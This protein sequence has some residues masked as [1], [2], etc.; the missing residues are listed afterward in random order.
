MATI[1][2]RFPG[3]VEKLLVNYVGA[4][5][6]KGDALAQIYSPQFI[7]AAEEY[8]LAIQSGTSTGS[9]RVQ[10]TRERLLLAGFTDEQVAELTRTRQVPTFITYHSP[11]AGT[12]LEKK[13]VEGDYLAEGAPL[14]SV[15]DLSRVWV[16]ARVLESDLASVK[17]GQAVEVTSVAYPGIVFIGNVSFIYPT[18]E[19]DSR[20]V[21]VRI[22][23]SNRDMLLRPGMYVTALL[24]SPVGG[25]EPLEPPDLSHL[26]SAMSTGTMEMSAEPPITSATL[27]A[28]RP[29]GITTA[30]GG[31]PQDVEWQEGYT[32]VMHPEVLQE[33]GGLCNLCDCGMQMTKW[34]R[35]KVLAVPENAVIDTGT[36][37][38]VYVEQAAGVFD[39]RQVVLGARSGLW[40][41]VLS[42]LKPGMEVATNGS[43]LIDAENRLNP[44]SEINKLPTETAAPPSEPTVVVKGGY[45]P[46]VLTIAAGNHAV[47]SS[48]AGKR[49]HAHRRWSSL[50]SESRR[51]CLRSRRRSS[52]CPPPPPA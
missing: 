34:R 15:A 37:K 50:R 38:F 45:E 33:R 26:A 7:A 40:Y 11:I 9:S 39:A 51:N 47:S 42:G 13:A 46:E 16:Q 2:N 20:S 27:Y 14:F 18:V 48:T 22:E 4:K 19:P 31:A 24:R 43:F 28:S 41:P 36:R 10:A 44:A 30:G 23:V 21:K 49:A 35:E 8:L 29:S 17:R 25:F 1:A 32:C 3:R 52:N 6:R 5:V 12:V